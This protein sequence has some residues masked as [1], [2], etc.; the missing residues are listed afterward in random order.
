MLSDKQ[1]IN[2]LESLFEY[3]LEK[4]NKNNGQ[5]AKWS[6]GY[7]KNQS[8]NHVTTC[9]PAGKVQPYNHSSSPL[10]QVEIMEEAETRKRLFENKTSKWTLPYWKQTWKQIPKVSKERHF[11]DVLGRTPRVKTIHHKIPNWAG[12]ALALSILPLLF[13]GLGRVSAD[14]TGSAKAY[15]EAKE[16]VLG[17]GGA[18]PEPKS[19]A[20]DYLTEAKNAFTR[21]QEISK[22]QELSDEDK[23]KITNLINL[24]V[25]TL[26]DGIIKHPQEASLYFERATIYKA[27]SQATPEM[28]EK[29]RAD[30]EKTLEIAPNA[31][32]VLALYG[33]FLVEEMELEK[34]KI[35]FDQLLSLLPQNSQDYQTVAGWR[36]QLEPTPIPTKV[37]STE[38]TD[39]NT[40]ETE[41]DVEETV[42][43]TE[44]MVD[45]ETDANE[46]EEMVETN[47]DIEEADEELETPEDPMEAMKK[48]TGANNTKN[49]E[50]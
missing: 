15:Y 5:M 26:S 49:T 48:E 12:Y 45:E 20:E 40:D 44:E 33:R 37:N 27:L 29:V 31:P 19:S 23:N 35:V 2:K 38:R 16:S 34:A 28:K 22:E 47:E 46:T 32:N 4:E 10:M 50:I 43:N 30:L 11:E 24:A 8:N 42:E 25:Q 9:L 36:Q 39:K 18:S 6:D 3:Y 17:L 21:A 1:R 13:F 14:K 7:K 41:K